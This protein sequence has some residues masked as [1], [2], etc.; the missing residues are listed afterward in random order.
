M[1]EDRGRCAVC[2]VSGGGIEPRV[3]CQKCEAPHCESCWD[4][5]N[6]RCAIYGCAN[7]P[8]TTP[9]VIQQVVNS[10][11]QPER[12]TVSRT[13]SFDEAAI[14]PIFTL[15][16]ACVMVT[17]IIFDWKINNDDFYYHH[18]HRGQC[19]FDGNKNEDLQLQNY[20]PYRH[21]SLSLYR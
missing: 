8:V 13:R 9:V 17:A 10:D 21:N 5:N 19:I 12:R 6:K 3:Y 7:T 4:F 16:I 14:M 18:H 20:L 2:A 15:I 1:R 11:L